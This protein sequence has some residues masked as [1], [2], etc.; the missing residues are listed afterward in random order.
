M[1]T[2]SERARLAAG[3]G[4]GAGELRP[5]TLVATRGRRRPGLLLAGVTMVALG[6]LATMWLVSTSGDRVEVVMV[7]RDVP[8]GAQ[9]SAEDLTTTAVAVDPTVHVIAADAAAG[10]VGMTAAANLTAGS[11]LSSSDVT[12]GGVLGSGEVLVPL[13]MAFER[14]PAGGLVA[15]DHLLVVDAPPQGADPVPGAPSQFDA[16]VV[17]VGTPDV[18]GTVVVDVAASASDGA[19]LATRAATG[20]FAIVVLPAASS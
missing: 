9:L 13:P 18:N 8:Y 11:L 19:Q 2:T 10:L 12:P 20:R 6:A 17:R 16:R 14:V 1:T 7:A 5:A 4:T 15:G 3:P